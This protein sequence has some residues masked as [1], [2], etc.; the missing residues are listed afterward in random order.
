MSRRSE[1]Y[2]ETDVD[3][4][5]IR[6]TVESLRQVEQ[7]R[8]RVAEALRRRAIERAVAAQRPR[9]TAEDVRAVLGD[10]L[11]DLGAAKGGS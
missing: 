1:I 2:G 4:S 7:I 5:Q 9:V 10:A 3:P 6:F 11:A 8:T